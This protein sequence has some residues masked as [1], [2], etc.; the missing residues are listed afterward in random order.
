MAGPRINEIVAC[1][2]RYVRPRRRRIES[3][4][5]RAAIGDDLESGA[6]MRISPVA[7]KRDFAERTAAAQS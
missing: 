7:L 1:A 3:V 4:D 6:T 2:G 5:R